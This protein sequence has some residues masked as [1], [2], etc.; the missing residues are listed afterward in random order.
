VQAA[1]NCFKWR[2]FTVLKWNRFLC[3]EEQEKTVVK[4]SQSS[5]CYS[6][7]VKVLIGV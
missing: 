3:G 1:V 6:G 7:C 4:C 5:L 2:G